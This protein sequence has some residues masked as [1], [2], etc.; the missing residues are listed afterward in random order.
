M[1]AIALYLGNDHEHCDHLFADAEDAVGRQDWPEASDRLAAFK[2]A[3]LSHF[4]REE[5]ILFPEFEQR[6]GMTGG[7]T[8]VMRL[9][10]EQMRDAL[11]GMTTA[12]SDRDAD[13]YLGLAETLLMLM[14]QHNIKE[15]RI[16]YPMA[17][18][19]LSDLAPG[20]VARMAD[21]SA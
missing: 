13:T 5:E 4:A 9:E 19:A 17:D 11:E 10:H 3:I 14:R 6:T 1:N 18:Q 7:P 16:L 8:Q 21:L 20:L 12:V 15:E 2:L